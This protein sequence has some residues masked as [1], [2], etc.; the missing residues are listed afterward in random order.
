M[1]NQDYPWVRLQR[2]ATTRRPPQADTAAR[3]ATPLPAKAAKLRRS[4]RFPYSHSIV[5]GGLL[6]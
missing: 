3:R 4:R 6:V 2:P 1:C 5:P